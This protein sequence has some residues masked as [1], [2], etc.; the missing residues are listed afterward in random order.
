M[1]CGR[2]SG[3]HIVRRLGGTLVTLSGGLCAA[4]G[5]ATVALVPGWGASMAG[6]V[7]AG[8]GCSNIVPVFYTAVGRQKI[9][10]EHSAVSAVATPASWLVPR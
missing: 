9:M 5:L 2:L 3:D 7:L 10:A 6:Y 4:T 1:T 8:A